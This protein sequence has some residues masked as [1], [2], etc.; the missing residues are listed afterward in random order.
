M[1]TPLS[2]K[3]LSSF[4]V[5]AN[6]IKNPVLR[7]SLR[8]FVIT[9]LVLS[10]L[11]IYYK[12][13]TVRQPAVAN[14]TTAATNNPAINAVPPT[15]PANLIVSHK[16]SFIELASYC[17][18]FLA[19]IAGIFRYGVK[20]AWKFSRRLLDIF[21]RIEKMSIELKPNGGSSLYD[22]IKRIERQTVTAIER[23]RALVDSLHIVR[24]ESD[25]LGACQW[26]SSAYAELSGLSQEQVQGNGWITAVHVDDRV[27]VV[28]EWQ[29]CMQQQRTFLMSYRL[30][31]VVTGD[32]HQVA[33]VGK[34]ITHNEAIIGYVGT[35]TPLTGSYA[36]KY[37]APLQVIK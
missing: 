31:H 8:L 3:L 2:F 26:V 12:P 24:F 32:V 29:S 27:S 30:V 15:A 14:P 6:P 16:P 33:C 17:S 28:A 25:H 11:F 13:T 37:A 5:L 10:C 20:P 4:S 34:P 36:T 18:S 1:P 19:A 22:T 23:H 7:W 35:I 9:S 21:D